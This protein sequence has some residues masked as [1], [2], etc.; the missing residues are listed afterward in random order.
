VGNRWVQLVAVG[1]LAVLVL[2][3]LGAVLRAL[4]G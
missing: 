2:V 4:G 3:G 1:A